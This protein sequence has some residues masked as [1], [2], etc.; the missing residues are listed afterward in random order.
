M[1]H[2][3]V[4]LTI[5]LPRGRMRSG[6]PSSA[7]TSALSTVIFWLVS[8]AEQPTLPYKSVPLPLHPPRRD[9]VVR[10]RGA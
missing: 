8:A 4:R 9:H 2:D 1:E 7:I 3:H 10:I 5:P 6:S